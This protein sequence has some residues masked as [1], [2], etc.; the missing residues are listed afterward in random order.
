A[1]A[2]GKGGHA[3]IVDAAGHVLG[4]PRTDWETEI[5]DLSGVDPV[6]RMMKG[7]TGVS[8]FYSPAAKQDMIAGFT[9]VPSTGWG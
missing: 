8:K 4:H 2:F 3:A 5:K 6:A 1:V 9:S 7:E